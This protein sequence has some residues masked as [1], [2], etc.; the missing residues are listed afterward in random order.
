[1]VSFN[2]NISNTYMKLNTTK[3]IILIVL[4]SIKFKA[5]QEVQNTFFQFNSVFNNPAYSGSREALSVILNSRMQW[6]KWDGA[7]RSSVLTI[8][9]PLNNQKIGTG[10]SVV[11]DALGATRKNSVYGNVSYKVNVTKTSKLSLGFHSGV[12]FIRNDFS[13]LI[14]I[15][16]SDPVRTSNN[17]DRN[18]LNIGASIY[19]YSNKFYTALSCPKL[20]ENSLSIDNS[21]TSEQVRHYYYLLGYV[22]ES[23]LWSFKPALQVRYS[24]SAPISVDLNLSTYFNRQIS[25]SL[26]YRNNSDI[27]AN[28]VYH[29]N[30]QFYTG[31]AYDLSVNNMR[32]FNIG[33]HE[34]MIGFDFNKKNKSF[35]TPRYF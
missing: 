32:K 21:F 11:S 25:F 23:G 29:F 24:Q 7:P 28:V 30:E 17:F 14:I 13:N 20:L 9:S 35:L 10:I 26:F 31:Y 19:F 33:S 8:H 34:I 3:L 2:Y 22:Y 1:M 5:Q 18:M 4:I 15:D 27:G 6:L 16:Q 12:D